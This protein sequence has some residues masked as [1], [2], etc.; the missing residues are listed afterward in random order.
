VECCTGCIRG[1]QPAIKARGLLWK[2]AQAVAVLRR[3]LW[4]ACRP[5][6]QRSLLVLSRAQFT[7]HRLVCSTSSDCSNEIA[8]DVPA[9]KCLTWPDGIAA[10]GKSFGP[11]KRQTRMSQSKQDLCHSTWSLMLPAADASNL[12]T[13]AGL[14][15]GRL[16]GPR[17]G[18]SC[19]RRHARHQA[20]M[21]PCVF[22]A[23]CVPQSE[24]CCDCWQVSHPVA[25]CPCSQRTRVAV[26]AGIRSKT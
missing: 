21:L 14:T 9:C 22:K 1:Q 10:D 3:V 17:P 26:H 18:R 11:E 7:C 16:P 24:S 19:Q 2:L 6:T 20:L 13:A 23:S 8:S 5:I 4:Q 12:K 15:A 25:C